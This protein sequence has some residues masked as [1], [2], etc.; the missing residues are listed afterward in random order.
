[1]YWGR[2]LFSLCV[3][4]V[5]EPI[6][7]PFCPRS[8]KCTLMLQQSNNVCLFIYFV[9]V[10]MRIYSPIVAVHL[11]SNNRYSNNSREYFD[12]NWMPM[13][14]YH[15]DSMIDYQ[16]NL[17]RRY[18]PALLATKSNCHHYCTMAMPENSR[19][20]IRKSI[21][22]ERF[23]NK[24]KMKIDLP[25]VAMLKKCF[26]ALWNNWANRVELMSTVLTSWIYQCKKKRF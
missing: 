18:S 11:Y 15:F 7:F 1:M 6:F 5:V 26:V 9:L 10:G 14:H 22:I 21:K 16:M 13:I 17:V 24:M 4:I 25:Y 20:I 8:I 19:S 3:P 2:W 12:T 23:S